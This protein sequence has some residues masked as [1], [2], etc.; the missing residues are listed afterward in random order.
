MVKINERLAADLAKFARAEIA[1]GDIDPAYPVL[2]HAGHALAPHDQERRL[3]LTF[4]YLSYYHLPSALAAF[5]AYPDPAPLR[6]DLLQLPTGT[7]RRAHRDVRRFRRHLDDYLTRVCAR[8]GGQQGWLDECRR[9]GPEP[10]YAAF[11]ARAQAVYGNGRWAA[12]K[13]AEL[14]RDVNDFPLAFPHMALPGSSGP[15]AGLAL[16]SEGPPDDGTALR[17]HLA[18]AH[19]LPLA[20]EHLETVLCDFHAL[21]DGR[22]YVG[23]DLDT[24]LL[25]ICT[26]PTLGERGRELL[27]AARRASFP[28]GYLGELGSWGGPDKARKRHY[29]RTGEVIL[30]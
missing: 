7:D 17:R 14:L 16:M 11:T 18:D 6:D 21:Y 10:T 8:P 9:P 28:A 1:T 30:R 22:Y 20:W 27:F 2:R 13:W 23:C 4:L 5:G 12:Y 26:H 25:Q 19:G 3:W 15:A 29:Q 24:M